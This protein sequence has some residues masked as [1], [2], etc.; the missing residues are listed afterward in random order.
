V[1]DSLLS[2]GKISAQYIKYLFVGRDFYPGG[3]LFSLYL[4]TQHSPR[5]EIG[6]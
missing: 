3:N 1:V 4:G 5:I 6:T 2:E